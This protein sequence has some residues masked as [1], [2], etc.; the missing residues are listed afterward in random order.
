ME[1]IL[2]LDKKLLLFLNSFHT[3][4][5]DQVML[6][7]TKTQ[8]WTPLYLVLIYLIFKKYNTEGWLILAGVVL[9]IL[10]SDQVTSSLMKPFFVRL[11]PS[12]DPSLQGLIHI[13]DGY[14][15][16]LYGFASGHAANTT[17]TAFFIWLL[18]KNQYRWVWTIFLW[19][20]LM[21]YTRIYLGVHYPGDIVVGAAVGIFCGYAGFRFYNWLSLKFKI[22]KE[23]TEG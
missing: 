22:R 17:A 11:R 10:L 12:Q 3:E 5:L 23:K 14:K 18:F 15:G 2:D 4:A 7:I 9:A 8:F 16:G 21:T 1:S 20:A 6:L 19:A 13:V